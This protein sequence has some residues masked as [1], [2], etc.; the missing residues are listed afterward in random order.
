MVL[1]A[2]CVAV[3]HTA[4]AAADDDSGTA[5]GAALSVSPD[6]QQAIG[7]VVA[8]PPAVKAPERI[9]AV[10][11]VLDPESLIADMGEMSAAQAAERATHAE[12]E[13]VR[14]LYGSGTNA[15]LKMLEAAQAEEAK[16]LAQA[17]LAAARFSHRW[18]P[19]ETQSAA[20]RRKIVESLTRG[21]G[22]LVRADMLGRQAVSIVPRQALLGVDGVEV[23]GRVLGVLRQS[24]ELQSVGLLL[25]VE[26]SPLG[27]SAGARLPVT[28]L[29]EQ[30]NGRLLRRDAIFFDDKGAYVFRRLAGKAGNAGNVISFGTVRVT[31][32]FASDD[33]WLVEGIDDDDAVVVHGAGA[34]WSLQEMHGEADDAAD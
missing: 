30:R 24:S 22:L 14:A 8:H 6:Q 27:L 25:A 32:L 5:P 19:F 2:T 15:S 18:G 1:I 9:E 26:R 34:L 23:P 16:N 10:G 3:A 21:T 13:R 7:I 20:E 28:L 12:L 33:G 17:Q 11:V 4:C 29:S 31:L